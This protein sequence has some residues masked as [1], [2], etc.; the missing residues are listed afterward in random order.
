MIAA[1]LRVALWIGVIDGLAA[2]AM[3]GFLYTPESNLLM[4]SLS[5]VL[6]IVATALLL[7]SSTSGAIALVQRI[8]PWKALGTAMRR[9]P[10]VLVAI[11]VVGLLCGAAGWFE[12]WWVARAGQVDAAAIAA[13]DVTNTRPLHATVHWLVVVVQWILV[14]AWLTTALAWIAGY[15]RRDVLGMK[16][17]TAGLHWRILLVTA[18]S[19][20]V[21]VWLP[22]RLVYWRPRGLPASSLEM[23]FTVAKLG[24]IY[25]LAQLGWAIALATA[26]GRVVAAPTVV[27]VTVADP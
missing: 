22:W 2:L 17:L 20:I 9:L 4:L 24:L 13:G 11:V 10:L 25:L 1:V 16:W 19:V 14:P 21:L 8:A 7:L 18:A 26:A 3:L 6:V 15:E 5:A 27:P 23:A 12:S